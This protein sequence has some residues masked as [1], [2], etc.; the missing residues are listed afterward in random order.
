MALNEWRAEKARALKI[1]RVTNYFRYERN[2][3]FAYPFM[4]GEIGKTGIAPTHHPVDSARRKFQD[5]RQQSLIAARNGDFRK[6]ARLTAEATRLDREI[7]D[8]A[9]GADDES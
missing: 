6:V 3:G 8:I 7:S 4:T 1:R 9:S 5:V 2:R